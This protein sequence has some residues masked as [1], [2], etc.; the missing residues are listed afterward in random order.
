MFFD[1]TVL[2]QLSKKSLTEE[3]G[4]WQRRQLQYNLKNPRMNLLNSTISHDLSLFLSKS[5]SEIQKVCVHHHFLF[6]LE[7]I[8]MSAKLHYIFII[9][10]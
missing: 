7:I 2:T 5:N 9:Y 4:W 8:S 3:A 6:S 1:R 10:I